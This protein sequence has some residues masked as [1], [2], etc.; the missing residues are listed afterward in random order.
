MAFGPMALG[1]E[2]GVGVRHNAPTADGLL[3]EARAHIVSFR[4][5]LRRGS[6]RDGRVSSSRTAPSASQSGLMKQPPAKRGVTSKPQINL[7]AAP[8]V[9]VADCRRIGAGLRGSSSTLLQ[10]T[11]DGA[12]VLGRGAYVPSPRSMVIRA[13]LSVCR[14]DEL[15][16]SSTAVRC[17]VRC[18][19][20]RLVGQRAPGR[21]PS[22]MPNRCCPRQPAGG[23]DRSVTRARRMLP[24]PGGHPLPAASAT[25]RSGTWT[26]RIGRRRPPLLLIPSSRATC[27]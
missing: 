16:S 12:C 23:P 20:A 1:G 11:D 8:R 22:G 3:G 5:E 26:A 19:R 27:S 18:H 13:R 15:R 2:A 7:R 6:V 4:R 17:H 25:P 10:P 21:A 24:L 14:R 9:T